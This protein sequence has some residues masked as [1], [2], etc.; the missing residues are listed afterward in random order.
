LI[1]AKF[2]APIESVRRY[3]LAQGVARGPRWAGCDPGQWG[4]GIRQP[5]DLRACGL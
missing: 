3:G 1:F 2:V 5:A 4:P